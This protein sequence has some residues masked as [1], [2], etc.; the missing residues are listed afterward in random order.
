MDEILPK[1]SQPSKVM[2]YRLEYFA[3][4][5]I[6]LATEMLDYPAFVVGGMDPELIKR[7]QERMREMRHIVIDEIRKRTGE[8]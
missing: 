4:N 6:V 8:Q 2:L 5:H 3:A 1:Q 7:S